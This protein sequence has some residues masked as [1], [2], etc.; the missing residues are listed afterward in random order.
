VTILIRLILCIG[1]MPPTVCPLQP[2]PAPLR[3]I[4]RG[5]FV[6]LQTGSSPDSVPHHRPRPESSIH[7]WPHTAPR[8]VDSLAMAGLFQ[9]RVVHV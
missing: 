5:F 8:Q 9:S 3:A 7:T 2:P 6:L 1:S 4:A